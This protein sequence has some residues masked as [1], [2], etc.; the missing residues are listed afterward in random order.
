M[1]KIYNNP[2]FMKIIAL[3]FAILLF[4]YVNS[5]NN[6]VQTSGIDGLSASTTDTIFEVPIVV[7]I[8]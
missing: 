8:D 4:T 3:A 2:W 5:S 7:E 6:R 1:E